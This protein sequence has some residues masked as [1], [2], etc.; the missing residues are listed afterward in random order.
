M[1]K[2]YFIEKEWSWKEIIEMVKYTE[3]PINRSLIRLES[4]DKAA[5]EAFLCLR[6]YMG[7]EGLKKGQTYT[8]CVYQLLSICHKNV[9]LRDEVYCQLI[10]QTTANKNTK[11]NSLVRA[12]RLFTIITAYYTCSETLKPYLVKYLTDIAQDNRRLFHGL[13]F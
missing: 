5:V 3:K 13:I 12:W 8:D 11:Q 9:L 1:F 10:K 7:D 4:A 6:R 2:V